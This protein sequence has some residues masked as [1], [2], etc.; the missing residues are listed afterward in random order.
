MSWAARIQ[1]ARHL[2]NLGH[3]KD[4]DANVDILDMLLRD[5]EAHVVKNDREKVSALIARQA[6]R[7]RGSEQHGEPGTCRYPETRGCRLE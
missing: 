5:R 4:C 7:L 1:Y 2:G 3:R 6:N